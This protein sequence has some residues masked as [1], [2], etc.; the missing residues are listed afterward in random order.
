MSKEFNELWDMIHDF[1]VRMYAFFLLTFS[2]LIR[3][4]EGGEILVWFSF[5]LSIF[6]ILYVHFTKTT[7]EEEGGKK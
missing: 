7:H 4:L 3:I 5:G 1:E 2:L 6:L